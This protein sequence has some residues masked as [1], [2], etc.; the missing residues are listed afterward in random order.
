MDLYSYI[1]IIFVSVNH[2]Q[3]YDV[4][5]NIELHELKKIKKDEKKI[6]LT[7]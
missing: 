3:I 6:K 5:Q 1:F 2:N 4:R 7:C